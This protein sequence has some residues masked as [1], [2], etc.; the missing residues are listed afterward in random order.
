MFLHYTKFAKCPLFDNMNAFLYC[1]CKYN[2]LEALKRL[3]LQG[4]NIHEENDSALITAAAYG[5][6]RIVQYL[7]SRG[8][9]VRANNDNA[10]K[11]AS[12]CREFEMIAYLVS[13]G[14]STTNLPENQVRYASIYIRNQ[15]RRAASRIYFWWIPRCYDMSR[16]AGIR[17][18][19]RN[20]EAFETLCASAKLGI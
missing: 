17:M 8:A 6:M 12:L 3:E 11:I 4:I 13:Q 9:N 2:D 5:H 15:E 1:A 16:P 7:V 20:L 14:A 19:Y 10:I 18:A